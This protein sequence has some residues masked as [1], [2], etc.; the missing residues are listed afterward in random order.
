[1]V[2]SRQASAIKGRGDA[3]AQRAQARKVRE[4]GLS[5]WGLRALAMTA[6]DGLYRDSQ[7]LRA[8]KGALVKL[9]I[10]RATVFGVVCTSW[11]KWR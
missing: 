11:A 1:M 5:P 6:V 7:R 8:T 10:A 2:L 9:C 3:T 4:N